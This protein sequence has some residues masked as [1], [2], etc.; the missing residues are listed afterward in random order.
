MSEFAG[1]CSQIWPAGFRRLTI[2]L[3]RIAS[4][5]QCHAVTGMAARC[6]LHG[7][8]VQV[9]RGHRL[10]RTA[11][12]TVGIAQCECEAGWTVALVA[13]VTECDAQVAVRGNHRFHLGRCKLAADRA[14]HAD[15]LAIKIVGN[16]KGRD[17]SS[18]LLPRALE[19]KRETTLSSI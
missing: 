7:V 12:S 2:E 8:V 17:C 19:F 14:R 6:P 3:Q 9:F 15:F 11:R 10:C 16:V 4:H 5:G 13:G 18:L 1:K